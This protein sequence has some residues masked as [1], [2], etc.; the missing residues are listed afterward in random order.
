MFWLNAQRDGPIPS[1][2]YSP[3]IYGIFRDGSNLGQ[4]WSLFFIFWV[5][6]IHETTEGK[7]NSSSGQ[8]I[9]SST[10]NLNKF[11]EQLILW[12]RTH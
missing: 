5:S 2:Y 1:W 3:F 6:N 8:Y 10:D 9:Q 12:N 4:I 11:L 7:E